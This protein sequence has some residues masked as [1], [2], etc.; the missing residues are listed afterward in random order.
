MMMMMMMM[1]TTTTTTTTMM[2]IRNSCYSRI[3]VGSAKDLKEHAVSFVTAFS[4][5]LIE[6]RRWQIAS[7]CLEYLGFRIFRKVVNNMPVCTAS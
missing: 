5:T 3:D 6:W 4:A 7:T 2:M 1:T